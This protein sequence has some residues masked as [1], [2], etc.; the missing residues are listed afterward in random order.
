[1]R[2]ADNVH[3]VITQEMS[4]RKDSLIRVTLKAVILDEEG[5]ILVV[6][7]RGRDWWDI[8]GG[9][10][11]HGET[12]KD[13]L[14][15][16]LFEEV[17]LKG[18]FE[19]ETLLAEDPRYLESLNLYQMRLTFIVKPHSMHFESG[20]DGDEIKFVDAGI[21]E[22]SKL[23]TERQIFMFSSLAKKRLA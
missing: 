4:G 1:M 9:G 3:G 19:Y 20:S 18:D 8:P 5:R 11:D 10:I 14:A 15:R 12:I 2:N 23:W 21:Y 13:A 22:N 6:K 7:E 16:E 17:S